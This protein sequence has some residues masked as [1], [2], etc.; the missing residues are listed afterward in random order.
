MFTLPLRIIFL[1]IYGGHSDS[2]VGKLPQCASS[3]PFIHFLNTY[4][5][6]SNCTRRVGTLYIRHPCYPTEIRSVFNLD[7]NSRDNHIHDLEHHYCANSTTEGEMVDS[8]V[9]CFSSF[10]NFFLHVHTIVF[11][12]VSTA[13]FL[14]Y[15]LPKIV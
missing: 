5:K 10:F 7:K 12:A 4:T 3:A 13:C 11:F 1:Y 15:F 14:F 2:L 9:H 8:F 6:R